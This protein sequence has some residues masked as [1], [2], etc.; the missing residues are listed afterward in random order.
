MVRA[1]VISVGSVGLGVNVKAG[2]HHQAMG[3]ENR[4]GLDSLAHCNVY[5]M[6]CCPKE[7]ETR[8]VE[9]VNAEKG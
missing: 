3:I 8:A 6:L 2:P 9:K 4:I 1:V 5:D 7:S